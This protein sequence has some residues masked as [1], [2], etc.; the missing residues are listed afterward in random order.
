MKNKLN[1]SS[2]ASVSLLAVALL[3][4]PQAQAQSSDKK[5]SLYAG[6]AFF[7]TDDVKLHGGRLSPEYHLNGFASIVG[8]FSYEKGSVDSG[9]SSLTTYLGGVRLK[10][11]LGGI[12]VYVHALAGGAKTT[13]SISPF[14]GV[15]ISVSDTG[16]GLDGGGGLEF[17]ATG[18][19]KVRVGADYFRRKLD[20]G[21][22][23]VNENDI[24]AT[25]G[26]VF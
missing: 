14:G 3:I 22:T 18:S 25:V 1:L 24:R 9:K 20:V 2:F 17:K 26:V 4:A 12:S 8:D 10:R 19:L 6:Y 16:L 13:A 23:K 11:G 15:N 5:V 7:K 21:G